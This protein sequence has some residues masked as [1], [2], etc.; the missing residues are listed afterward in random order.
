MVFKSEMEQLKQRM[1]LMV[2]REELA[3]SAQDVERLSLLLQSM[4]SKA[5]LAAAQD[6]ATAL[7]EDIERLKAKMEGMVA[8]ANLDAAQDDLRKA[9][10]EAERLRQQ[11]AAMV[12][13]SRL[14]TALKEAADRALEIERLQAFI[15]TMVS[16]AVLEK[17][18]D[19]VR[20][21]QAE[22]ARLVREIGD[23]K[24]KVEQ[25]LAPLRPVFE[26]ESKRFEEPFAMM[27]YSANADAMIYCTVDGSEPGP[28]NCASVF[29]QTPLTI[30]VPDETAE[31][32]AACV[33][34]GRRGPVASRRFTKAEK[35]ER[36]APPRDNAGIG[37]VFEAMKAAG[38]GPEL[39]RVT[40]KEVVPG[41]AAAV[42]GCIEPGDHILA[43]DD[44]DVSLLDMDDIAALI[45]GVEGTAVRLSLLRPDPTGLP[46]A[47]QSS[48]VT[49]LRTISPLHVV[50]SQPST[51]RQA[52][53]GR[54]SGSLS[55]DSVG[56]RV[57]DAQ[58]PHS[59]WTALETFF[60]LPKNRPL[61]TSSSDS[62]NA[63]DRF[64]SDSLS[65]GS[66]PWQ[67]LPPPPAA[68]PPYGG[69][70]RAADPPGSSFM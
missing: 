32:K 51:P 26:F 62:A 48:T 16:K 50:K 41:G 39:S 34:L 67:T 13:K 9:A 33:C 58:R 17:S 40:V 66:Q 55:R 38:P 4:V 2:P 7:L 23:L 25:L 43:V 44:S 37:V 47:G 60:P 28:E 20:R 19:E 36:A 21:L 22:I 14:D 30:S 65:R 49:L 59:T 63:A 57:S 15:A 56:L 5:K 54:S 12:P 53:T 35:R 61:L 68:A 24:D 6:Q 3:A 18:E 31:V 69:S 29:G 10:E 11:V 52:L 1:E 46:G 8:R 70:D 27:V 64:S 42:H 45:R